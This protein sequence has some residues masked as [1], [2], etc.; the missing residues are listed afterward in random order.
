MQRILDAAWVMGNAAYD[1]TKL[2][3]SMLQEIGVPSQKPHFPRRQLGVHVKRKDQRKTGRNERNARSTAPKKAQSLIQDGH[4]FTHERSTLV[5]IIEGSY[6]QDA[7]NVSQGNSRS[8]QKKSRVDSEAA[9]VRK[10]ERTP[11]LNRENLR[12]ISGK[13]KTR[14]SRDDAEIQALERKLGVSG[15]KGHSKAFENDG[16]DEFLEGLEGVPERTRLGKRKR[17][18]AAETG[19]V[20]YRQS[21]Y[22]N[23]VAANNETVDGSEFSGFGSNADENDNDLDAREILSGDT[24]ESEANTIAFETRTPRAT[25]EN[26]YVAPTQGRV[27]SQ[28]T[29]YIPPSLRTSH[30]GPSED[31][32]R[33]KRQLRGSLNRLSESN[34]LSIV[35]EVGRLYQNSPRQYVS[36]TL[37][38]LLLD[39]LADASV[40]QDTYIILHS[41]F[42]AALHKEL[43][44]DF[45]AQM[46]MSIDDEFRIAFDN[47]TESASGSKKTTNL[48]SLLA[49]MYVFQVIGSGLIFDYVRL[50]LR[51][52]SEHNTELLLRIVRIAGQQLKYDD[53]SALRDIAAQL[54]E[55]VSLLGEQ[56][57]SIRTRFMVETIDNLKN[58]KL[59]TG[60]SAASI[61][62]EHTSSMKRILG[63]L[64][65]QSVKAF[66][67]LGV[68]LEDIRNRERKGKWWLVGASYKGDN[69][70][71]GSQ[72]ALQQQNAGSATVQDTTSKGT[73]DL[74]QLSKSLRMNT[75]VRRA[76]FVAAMSATDPNDAFLRL[77]KLKLKRI[78]EKE[79]PRVIVECAGAE[80]VYNPYYTFLSKRICSDIQLKKA[81]QF[82]L[83]DLFK[84]FGENEHGS[85]G[86]D[87]DEGE[88][89]SKLE[90]SSVVNLARMFGILIAD[91]NLSLGVLKVLNLTY[92]H[93]K[94]RTFLEVLLTTIVIHTQ[95][96]HGDERSETSL[97]EVLLQPKEMPRMATSLQYFMKTI[98]KK[99]NIASSKRDRNIVKW[100]CRVASGALSSLTMESTLDGR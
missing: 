63:T 87:D 3:K 8:I 37:I 29:K 13:A 60:K 36:S 65:Q 12:S 76:V 11:S 4:G 100:G 99:S 71:T 17:D 6:H 7:D 47:Y 55:Q 28:K 49:E 89:G 58:H 9:V 40:L 57:L 56:T 85:D 98:M 82:S 79:I 25:R 70:A 22:P 64:N 10:K 90:L 50:C 42:I 5:T 73:V 39:S 1:T 20:G 61:T 18:D 32:R 23:D 30:D 43:G 74:M 97:L 66:E 21:K 2:P 33:L 78:Q 19:E 81:F 48:I 38:R 77:K 45:G 34:V 88:S 24:D 80:K 15:K 27:I 75:D 59:K 92:L 62:A 53:P 35:S 31:E 68:R 72:G 83:W 41:G 67:P 52:M 54:H 93:A 95:H 51:D 44:T 16:L 46:L 94:T 26:P 91:G 84:Q 96:E 14:L 69:P 86:S